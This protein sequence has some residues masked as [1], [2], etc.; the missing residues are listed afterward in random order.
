M[1][2]L[3]LDSSAVLAIL[4]EEPEAE[5]CS[6]RLVDASYAVISAA[7]ALE[8]ALR[9][10]RDRADDRSGVLDAFIDRLGVE[11]RGMDLA[12]YRA[13]RAA[14]SAFGKGRHPAGLNFGDCFAYALAKTLDAP[15]LFVGQD[16]ARTDIAS[17]L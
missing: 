14:F 10:G 7:N 5:M 4:L 1:S 12:Q 15:L 11:V 9:L 8:C 13:A 2:I 3:A 6:Q 16:F 17:A